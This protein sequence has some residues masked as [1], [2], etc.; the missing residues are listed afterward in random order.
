MHLSSMG[1][2]TPALAPKP[3]SPARAGADFSS[4]S[5]A[6]GAG[7]TARLP[8][9][10]ARL[11]GA[12]CRTRCSRRA[13]Q[14][15]QRLPDDRAGQHR[16]GAGR[17]HGWRPGHLYRHRHAGRRGARCRLGADEGRRAARQSEALRQR[18]LGRRGPADRRLVGHA[19]S[20]D[21]YR[22]A[23]ATARAMLV[24]A[25]AKSWGVEAGDINVE[26]GIVSHPSGM[27]ASFGELAP[28]A[29]TGSRPA[30]SR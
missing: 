19:S 20:W 27:R 13:E 29:A 30:R 17:A 7:L 9:A 21:R 8:R 26:A 2:P 14:S 11:G 5:A 23:G 3:A 25:A 4:A 24:E 18:G 15:D 16:D 28:L 1:P 12:G 10:R 6:A 22:R